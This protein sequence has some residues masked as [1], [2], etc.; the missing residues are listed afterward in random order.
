MLRSVRRPRLLLLVEHV[1]EE[2]HM[3][4]ILQA[5]PTIPIV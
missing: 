4:Q 5:S 3:Q 2:A 1:S